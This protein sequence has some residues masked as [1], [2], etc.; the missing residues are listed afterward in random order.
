MAPV[1]AVPKIKC[2]PTLCYRTI[3]GSCNNLNFPLWG[4]SLTSQARFIPPSY[5][6]ST[7]YNIKIAS[8]H[9]WWGRGICPH[10]SSGCCQWPV[11]WNYVSEKIELNLYLSPQSKYVQ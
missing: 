4:K 8:F 9:F 1:C 7:C 6:D 2:D 10:F 3:D 11:L 5:D